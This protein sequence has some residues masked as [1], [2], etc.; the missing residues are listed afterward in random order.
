ME[1]RN[2]TKP[3]V[4]KGCYVDLRFMPGLKSARLSIDIPIEQSNEFLSMFGAP[5]RAN[6]VWVAVARLQD[7]PSGANKENGPGPVVTPVPL[8][9]PAA[10][11]QDKQRTYTRS[12]IAALKLRDAAFIGWFASNYV[13]HPVSRTEGY[14][15]SFKAF[16][17]IKS[18]S[19]LDTPGPAQ[20]AF[21][22]LLATYDNREFIR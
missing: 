18:K 10:Q 14:E 8:P 6:P 12:Q 11:G 15:P 5:D 1:A 16:L 20:E 4:V 9:H 2:M 22:C 13:H 21:D 7:A 3:S 19:E 17:G